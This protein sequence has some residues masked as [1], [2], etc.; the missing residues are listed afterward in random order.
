[1]YETA[2]TVQIVIKRVVMIVFAPAKVWI[3]IED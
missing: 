1:V 3:V 2:G